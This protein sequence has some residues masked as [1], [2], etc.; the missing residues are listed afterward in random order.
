MVFLA[1]RTIK[2]RCLSNVRCLGN[3]SKWGRRDLNPHALRH[4]I[5]SH[6]R[7]PIPTLP[8][9]SDYTISNRF[10]KLLIRYLRQ[11]FRWWLPKISWREKGEVESEEMLN[12]MVID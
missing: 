6:A 2:K 12:S 1:R 4:M 10:A 5:L 9:D 3:A 8:R 11:I 7:L